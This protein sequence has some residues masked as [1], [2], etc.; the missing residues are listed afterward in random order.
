MATEEADHFQQ[1]P[2]CPSWPHLSFEEVSGTPLCSHSLYLGSGVEDGQ[3]FLVSDFSSG[4][5]KKER[6]LS[7]HNFTVMDTHHEYFNTSISL[8][9]MY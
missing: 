1:I 6:L 4:E 2:Q 8:L 7:Q 5:T 3:K 9:G